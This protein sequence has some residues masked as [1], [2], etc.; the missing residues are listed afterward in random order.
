MVYIVS[1]FFL[2]KR[3]RN[4]EKNRR[5]VNSLFNIKDVNSRI[6]IEGYDSVDFTQL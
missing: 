1:S 3:I 2:C 6:Q 5:A 4:I